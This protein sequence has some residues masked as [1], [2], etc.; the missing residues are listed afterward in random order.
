MAGGSVPPSWPAQAGHPRLC[1][2]HGA[3][4]GGASPLRADGRNRQPR[5]T[6]SSWLDRKR[7][8]DGWRGSRR[9]NSELTNRHRIPG[10]CGGVTRQRTGTP[11]GR[12][13]TR[14]GKSGS[15][16]G[17]DQCLTLGGPTVSPDDWSRGGQRFPMDDEK[18]A[19][20][21]AVRATG[22]RAE[23]DK[24]GAAPAKAGGATGEDNTGPGACEEPR[25]FAAWDQE[26]AP[27]FAGA[28]S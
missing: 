27:A 11:K 4:P 15:H 8:S 1:A 25:A 20:A 28:G 12:S 10:R 2:R 5:A 9:Q 21:V 7:R 26:R 17:K 6:A 23:F 19:E 16:R 18:S 22:R 13:D 24:Q 3:D 14:T